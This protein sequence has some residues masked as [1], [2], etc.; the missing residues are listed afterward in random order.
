MARSIKIKWATSHYRYGVDDGVRVRF[1]VVC[2]TGL[3]T[4]VFAYR[5]LPT[6]PHGGQEGFFSHICSPVDLEEYPADGPTAGCSPE[7]FR[8]SYVDVLV[9]SVQEA[10]DFVQIVRE[11]VRRI[12]TTL[13]TMDTLFNEGT[14]L[15]GN[16]PTCDPPPS[17]S[18]SASSEDS[19]SASFGSLNAL[20]AV[21]TSELSVGSGVKWSTIGTGAGSPIG[22]SDSLALNR[23]RV[24]LCA[25]EASQLLLVQGFDFSDLPDD[26]IIEG[27][28][29]RVVL[30]DATHELPSSSSSSS[31][32]SDSSLSSL[33]AQC[34]RLSFL[35]L[36]HPSLG[37]GT[38]R[39]DF[40]CI[41]GPVWETLTHG[42][43]GDLWGFPQIFGRDLKDGAFGLSLVVSN[44]FQTLMSAA[45][46]DGVELTVYFREEA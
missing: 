34:P 38:N 42:G 14:E 8:L 33:P 12:I 23:S 46:V 40:E 21:G 24:D 19:S 10:A 35:A 11:D 22:S 31:A 43:S 27:I 6:T 28:E 5:M 32:G 44:T 30:R 1:D 20:T 39:G 18:S 9:R 4:R 17:S 41:G 37:L 7:W 15:M 2:A 16:A 3:D 45:E 36:Q 26:A 25:G 29:S 13:E